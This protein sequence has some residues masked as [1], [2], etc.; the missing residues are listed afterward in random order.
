MH[1]GDGHQDLA[2]DVRHEALGQG[3]LG[4]LALPHEGLQIAAGAVV[5][6]EV[7][8]AGVQ[9]V[10]VQLHNVGVVEAAEALDLIC[11]LV[12][13]AGELPG[14]P[15]DLHRAFLA[16]RPDRRQFHD[17]VGA[18]PEG[19]PEVKDFA[20]A[21]VRARARACA[22]QRLAVALLHAPCELPQSLAEFLDAEALAAALLDGAPE[23]QGGG[24]G[25]QLCVQLRARSGDGAKTQREPQLVVHAARAR[26]RMPHKDAARL[27]VEAALAEEIGDPL[28]LLCARPRPRLQP[29]PLL[30]GAE[31]L[32][33]I[34]VKPHSARLRV[35]VHNG[36]RKPT[37]VSLAVA[38][39]L[40]AL[41]QLPGLEGPLGGRAS[42]ALVCRI[43]TRLPPR[44][45]LSLKG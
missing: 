25:A 9:V 43:C 21:S 23:R 14:P 22:P 19:P 10:P 8:A 16:A 32:G 30:V 41:D 2:H 3:S 34:H 44:C 28:Q 20:R 29:A 42:G 1:V 36:T 35:D 4:L 24:A 26:L 11:E 17:A 31:G 33:R 12:R 37:T 5:H 18:L 39:G 13:G 27:L 38:L 45:S 40:A 15:D 7:D 6:D